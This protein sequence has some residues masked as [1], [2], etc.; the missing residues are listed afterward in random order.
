MTFDE[1]EETQ[2][3][4]E[5]EYIGKSI[6]PREDKV[7]TK[8][9]K[10]VEGD[11]ERLFREIDS[12]KEK[13]NKII[14]LHLYIEKAIDRIISLVL[15]KEISSFYGKIEF[16]KAKKL[17][18]DDQFHNLK[19]INNLRNDYAHILETELIESKYF[20]LVDDLKLSG[21]IS[22]N[23]H[24]DK[25]QLIIHQILF[26][27]NDIYDKG[28][29][30]RGE[31]KIELGLTDAEI[32]A[33]LEGE[34]KLSWQFCKILKY[35]KEVYDERYTLQCPYCNTGEIIRMK[36]GTPGF[37]DSFFIGCTNCGLDGDGSELKMET[38]KRGSSAP[39]K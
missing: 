28:R 3:I 16:L 26:E 17:I 21:Y 11:Y 33:K 34:G 19:I 25:F 9:D 20:Q 5:V 37:K 10:E 6:D 39:V 31:G 27:L 24:H 1:D 15:N 29:V 30:K 4:E 38:I 13:R 22:A 35:E 14:T 23:P 36:E 32:K 2:I 7:I 8:E 18:N 12:I